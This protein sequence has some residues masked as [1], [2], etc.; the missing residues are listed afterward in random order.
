MFKSDLRKLA[1][2]QGLA[3]AKRKDSQGICFVGKVDLPV[4]L[5]QKLAPKDGEVIEIAKEADLPYPGNYT[6]GG[7]Y[8]P[9]QLKN[10]CT[11]F[12]FQPQLGTVIGKHRGAHYYTIGQR[13]GLNIGGKAEPLFVLA[14]DI[15]Q[16]TIYVGQG[17]DH[18]G[19]NRYGS[20]NFV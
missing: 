14:T 9:E 3:T 11:P 2:E 8:S 18:P 4:F 19:L 16:N 13:K 12:C 10:I 15:D 1:E 17:H 20:Y 6:P 7:N 5:Q